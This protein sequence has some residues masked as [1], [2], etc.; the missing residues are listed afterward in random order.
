MVR[1]PPRVP[2][3]WGAPSPLGHLP[4]P[5]GGTVQTHRETCTPSGETGEAERGMPRKQLAESGGDSNTSS[6]ME[7]ISSWGGGWSRGHKRDSVR[8]RCPRYCPPYNSI[9]GQ[10]RQAPREKRERF[11]N[12]GPDGDWLASGP[13]PRS[14]LCPTERQGPRS[15]TR[16]HILSHQLGLWIPWGSW[17]GTVRAGSPVLAPRPPCPPPQGPTPHACLTKKRGVECVGPIDR[18]LLQEAGVQ[19]AAFHHLAPLSSSVQ[20]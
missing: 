11:M 3:L 9:P 6:G 7:L 16:W 18:I 10:G 19:E 1:G 5:A 17:Q 2:G 14:L 4:P 12:V 20:H 8:S 13:T 15:S